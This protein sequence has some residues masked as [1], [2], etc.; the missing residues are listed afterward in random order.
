MVLPALAWYRAAHRGSM[1]V[2]HK[3]EMD[4]EQCAGAGLP[5]HVRELRLGQTVHGIRSNGHFAEGRPENRRT[6]DALGFVW[7]K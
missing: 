6:L 1:D 2:P 4:A 7:N 3:F 5:A